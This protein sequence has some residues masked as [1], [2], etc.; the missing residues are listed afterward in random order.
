VSA[1]LMIS[2]NTTP[3][4]PVQ[5]SIYSLQYSLFGDAP[6]KLDIRSYSP[7]NI[8]NLPST[9]KK[10]YSVPDIPFGV[11]YATANHY[12]DICNDLDGFGNGHTLSAF[13]SGELSGASYSRL[14][15]D[16]SGLL[17]RGQMKTTSMSK[18]SRTKA[19]R[20]VENSPYSFPL[21]LTLT[22]DGTNPRNVYNQDGTVCHK[23]AKSELSRTLE[24]I[25]KLYLRL[26]KPFEYV[27]VAEIQEKTTGNI[28]FHILCTLS[29]LPA[30]T[31]RKLWNQGNSAVNIKRVKNPDRA[32]GYLLKYM[33]KSTTPILG[34][35]YQISHGLLESMQPVKFDFYGT[36]KQKIFKDTLAE[37][38][39][40]FLAG[41]AY[42]GDYGFLIPPPRRPYSIRQPDG[43]YLTPPVI[44]NHLRT[45]FLN[46]LAERLAAIGDYQLSNFLKGG[47]I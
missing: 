43:S 7:T 18:T 40:E 41:R 25:K 35:R 3:Y 27:W 8:T 22:F 36:D 46:T 17:K 37:Y 42:L 33:G 12:L 23:F 16:T 21:F 39:S 34:N 10:P 31:L 14:N 24:A 5:S 4:P 20:A 26:G 29:F 11:S 47:D 15:K 13:P 44:S 30:A 9:P 6:V 28:H 32:C 45:R 1:E 2:D 19:R 38:K